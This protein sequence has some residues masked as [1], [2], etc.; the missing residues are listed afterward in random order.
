MRDYSFTPVHFSSC[1][2]H[3]GFHSAPLVLLWFLSADS[4]CFGFHFLPSFLAASFLSDVLGSTPEHLPAGRSQAGNRHH[5]SRKTGDNLA[6][7]ASWRG[8]VCAAGRRERVVPQRVV[9]RRGHRACSESRGSAHR[10]RASH[11]QDLTQVL[12]RAAQ[13]NSAPRPYGCSTPSG[14]TRCSMSW[15]ATPSGSLKFR[16]R[17]TPHC[18]PQSH[19]S[20]PPI[21][22]G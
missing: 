16:T 22:I 13:P 4:V 20:M 8:S 1:S 7:G 9:T 11:V 2:L 15:K 3:F 6:A 19:S 12:R 14:E 17:R 5:N 21:T 18:G 10:L